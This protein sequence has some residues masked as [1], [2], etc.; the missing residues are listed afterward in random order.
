MCESYN[1]YPQTEDLVSNPGMC[2]DQELNQQL[3]GLQANSQSTEPY[4]TGLPLIL[5]HLLESA[6]G[7]LS[8]A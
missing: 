7:G 1:V 4:Q 8:E 2:P 5:F 6:T 3:F